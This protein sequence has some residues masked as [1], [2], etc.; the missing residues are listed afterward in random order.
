RVP[1]EAT[2]AGQAFRGATL[3]NATEVTARRDPGL[4]EAEQPTVEAIVLTR[5][6]SAMDLDGNGSIGLP[7]DRVGPFVVGLR[8]D[9]PS[10]GRILFLGTPSLFTNALWADR[11]NRDLG[12]AL[13]KSLVPEKARAFTVLVDEGRHHHAAD[14]VLEPL[15]AAVAATRTPVVAIALALFALALAALLTLR[16]RGP[17]DWRHRYAGDRKVPLVRDPNALRENLVRIVADRAATPEGAKEL[18]QE[19][20]VRAFLFDNTP[21][22]PEALALAAQEVRRIVQ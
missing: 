12:L 20:R 16:V 1:V 7:G 2:V 13:V 15:E 10:G 22:N 6:G 11:E 3:A 8:L 14:P 9:Y 19:P 21:P 18:V 4:P 17:E 5:E